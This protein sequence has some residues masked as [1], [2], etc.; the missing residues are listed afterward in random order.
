[1]NRSCHGQP[2]SAA[3]VRTHDTFTQTCSSHAHFANLLSHISSLIHVGHQP[4]YTATHIRKQVVLAEDCTIPFKGI[5]FK[6][7]A[8]TISDDEE[9]GTHVRHMFPSGRMVV[10][11]KRL[12]F[13]CLSPSKAKAKKTETAPQAPAAPDQM[14]PWV[15]SSFNYSG[16]FFA[17]DIKEVLHAYFTSE[18]RIYR[19]RIVPRLIAMM[20]GMPAISRTHKRIILCRTK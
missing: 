13:I 6:R 17:I 18:V 9:I 4:S 14:N 7:P 15:N 1:M 20:L 11:S 8:A 2:C 5:T 16:I 10:T 12:L 19:Q 3:I